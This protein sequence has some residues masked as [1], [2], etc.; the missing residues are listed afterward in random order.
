MQSNLINVCKFI[1]L[2]KKNDFFTISFIGRP[3][4]GKSTLF[5]KLAGHRV[6]L[7]DNTPN[8]TRD[9]KETIIDLFDMK[10]KL[11]DTAGIENFEEDNKNKSSLV[12]LTISQ[13]RKAL[14]FSDLAF[15]IVDGRAGITYD[16]IK[17]ARWLNNNK[18][19][20]NTSNHIQQTKINNNDND[21]LNNLSDRK[22]YDNLRQIKLKD[23]VKIPKIILLVNKT[24]DNFYP[25]EIYEDYKKLNLGEP[26]LISAEHGDNMVNY[27]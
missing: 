8:L 1:F 12:N 6:S 25:A 11:V 15:F 4:V 14:I 27:N 16:D 21:D 5:N 19:Q 13:T 7:V 3:N 22:F 20:P 9:R 10:I 2:S 23:E 18:I 24:E 17:L 26:T